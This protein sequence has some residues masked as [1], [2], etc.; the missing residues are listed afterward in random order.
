MIF[1][2]GP[3]NPRRVQQLHFGAD[4]DPLLPFGDARAV[5]GRRNALPGQPVNERRLADIG[6]ADDQA[7]TARGLMPLASCFSILSLSSSLASCGISLI[8]RPLEASASTAVCPSC[9]KTRSTAWSPRDRPNP[10]YL[11]RS[12]AVFPA[13]SRRSSGSGSIREAGRQAIRSPRRS[14]SSFSWI[15][16]RALVI[17][18]GN[19]CIVMFFHL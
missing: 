19:H 13:G 5:S 15:C 14:A 8:P 7:R 6:N 16:R 12:A 2:F 18:P 17:C 1:E 10:L 4:F 3:Q 11:K 9:L